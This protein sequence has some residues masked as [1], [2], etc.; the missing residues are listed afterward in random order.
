MTLLVMIEQLR[1]MPL[2]MEHL[3]RDGWQVRPMPDASLLATHPG[4]QDEEEAR[5]RLDR[6]DLLTSVSLRIAFPKLG[7]V[8]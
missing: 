5:S 2:L 7:G 4:V 6:L 3:H 1:P 8:S